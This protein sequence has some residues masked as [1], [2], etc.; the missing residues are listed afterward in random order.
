MVFGQMNE[1]PGARLR[2]GLS[3]LTIAEYFRDEAA[4][5]SFSLTTSSASFRQV[6][7]YR[8]C[9]AGCRAP[10]VTSNLA[11]DRWL[12][13]DHLDQ[14]RIDTSVQAV[15]PADDYTW[16]SR[17][18]CPPRRHDFGSS[19]RSPN[20]A[21]T[22]PS[23]RLPDLTH[24]RPARCRA[25]ALHVAREVQRMLQ[26]Y[27]DLQD[28]IAI[29]GIEVERRGQADRQPCSPHRTL[30][31]AAILYRRAVHR[32]AGSI[33]DPRRYRPRLQRDP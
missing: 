22:R 1:P 15:V 12:Q 7:R 14:D 3:G 2:V 32:H 23:T 33:R 5:F 16:H 6:P 19:A 25:G 9:S 31:L 29:L 8:R 30:L 27:R 28:I 26:R 24:P 21:S 11:A 4:T 18:N 17:D 20:A 10:S 13:V